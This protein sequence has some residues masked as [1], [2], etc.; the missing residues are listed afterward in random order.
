MWDEMRNFK[1]CLVKMWAAE[2]KEILF[3]E[4]AT[5]LQ[6]QK[7]HCIVE[8]VPVPAGVASRQAPLYFKKV[9]VEISEF[10]GR[11]GLGEACSRYFSFWCKKRPSDSKPP[12]SIGIY[13]KRVCGPGPAV[14]AL[15]TRTHPLVHDCPI[16]VCLSFIRLHCSAVSD[17]QWS[18]TGV[19]CTCRMIF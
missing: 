15:C 8:A 13:M 14:Y 11:R 7:R 6:R 17:G 4:T 2:G 12:N 16:I 18:W 1:K 19:I 9:R 10:G 5:Q 3:L